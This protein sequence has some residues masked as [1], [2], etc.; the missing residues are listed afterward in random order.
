MGSA[1]AHARG[2]SQCDAFSFGDGSF[3]CAGQST[4]FSFGYGLRFCLN[5]ECLPGAIDGQEVTILLS[6]GVFTNR[7]L[8]P[9]FVYSDPT[10]VINAGAQ[11]C[12]NTLYQFGSSNSNSQVTFYY[13]VGTGPVQEI[14]ITAP[15]SCTPVEV[16]D[17]TGSTQAEA[18]ALLES[19]GLR[20][21]AVTNASSETVPA[22]EIISQNPLPGTLLT[23]LS[24]VAV[25]IST[26]PAAGAAAPTESESDTSEGQANLTVEPKSLDTTEPVDT[27]SV[28]QST[29]TAE[30]DN[31]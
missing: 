14:T 19:I 13:Q 11:S 24:T 16:P 9:L 3:K 29:A 10:I 18:Q 12:T 26:G 2:A 5:S 15:P 27:G 21:G 20:L 6:M 30:P 4:G 7:R 17:L 8:D 28:D 25:T 1:T 31:G 22:G 23:P